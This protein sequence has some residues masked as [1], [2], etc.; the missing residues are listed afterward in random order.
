ME[1]SDRAIYDYLNRAAEKGKDAPLTVAT[2]FSG[3][4][5]SPE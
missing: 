5:E 3:T 4:R 1:I 2:Q